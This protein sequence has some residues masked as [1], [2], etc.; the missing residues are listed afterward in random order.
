M[1]NKYTVYVPPSFRVKHFKS[2][3]NFVML[4][5]DHFDIIQVQY[6]PF[7]WKLLSLWNSNNLFI[8]FVAVLFCMHAVH[9]LLKLFCKMQMELYLGYVLFILRWVKLYKY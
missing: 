3:R 7:N 4:I 1:R 5:K 9:I 2:M 6:F 8:D